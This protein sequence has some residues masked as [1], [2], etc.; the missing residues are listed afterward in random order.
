V[1]KLMPVLRRQLLV[2]RGSDST[3][4]IGH[5]VLGYS[6]QQTELRGFYC[7]DLFGARKQRQRSC[8]SDQPGKSLS[9]TPS[10]DQPKRGTAMA[11][12]G[13]GGRNAAMT[14]QRQIKSSPHAIT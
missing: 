7:V 5:G 10:R 13:I 14:R 6:I 8:L 1:R 2:P 11:K 3:D 4:R 12:N 9:P